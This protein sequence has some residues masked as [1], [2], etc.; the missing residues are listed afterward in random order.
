MTS[1]ARTALTRG[2]EGL[3]SASLAPVVRASDPAGEILRRGV[4]ISAYNLLE[5]FI[6]GRLD[7]L[8]THINL[9]HLHFGDLSDRLQHLATQNLL[10]VASARARRMPKQD[11]RSFAQRLGESLAAVHGGINLS[12]LTWLWS[13]SNMGVEDYITILKALHVK[14]AM[15]AVDALAQ[16]L[17]LAASEPKSELTE[18]GQQRHRAAHDSAHQITNLWIPVAIDQLVKF[19]ITFDAF[20]SVGAA[21]LRRGDFAF[22][23]DDNWT[24]GNLGVR[25]IVERPNGDWA[26]HTEANSSRAV[27]VDR[28]RHALTI[29]AAGR[30]S[31]RD[32]LVI[33]DKAGQI[34]DWSIPAVG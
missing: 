27:R 24:A 15:R 11:V 29:G 14:D 10:A 32:V 4:A 20:A 16:R 12:S 25:R 1:S 33:S 9:T 13:G 8:T 26:E 7:E 23:A 18:F 22:R 2:I 6:E 34:I 19:S 30:C 31:D 5:T 3:R 21:A 17:G 28:D